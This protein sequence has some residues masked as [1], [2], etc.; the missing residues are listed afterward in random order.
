L[1]LQPARYKVLIEG[2]GAKAFDNERPM[3]PQNDY[4]FVNGIEIKP[5]PNGFVTVTTSGPNIFPFVI[6]GV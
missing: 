1:R 2:P 3:Q 5:E 4:R 6:V